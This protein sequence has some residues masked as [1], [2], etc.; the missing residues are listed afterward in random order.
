MELPAIVQAHTLDL[1][2]VQEPYVPQ[3]VT[4][5]PGPLVLQ[6]GVNSKAA[7]YLGRRDIAC[8]IQLY[9][10]TS[11]C[12]VVHVCLSP[13]SSSFYAVSSYF[14]YS[15]DIGPHLHHLRRVLEALRGAR[16]VIGVN[17]NAHSPVWYSHPRHTYIGRGSVVTERREQM[18]S[19]IVGRGLRIAN[20]E[21]Q[22]PTFATANGE[23]HIDV[24]LTTGGVKLEDWQVK[25]NA[26]TSDHRLIVYLTQLQRL[27]GTAVPD[28]GRSE[29]LA[30]FV[31]VVWIGNAFKQRFT[32]G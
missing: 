32:I 2:L 5:V 30:S 24:T 26:S 7:I 10:C 16:V 28:A 15:Q 4:A 3:D 9:L 14:Q 1:V 18:E 21:G 20:T 8:P 11:H 25:L 6:A 27:T 29:L 12:M 22:T 13:G 31:S 19:F 17:S 23:S